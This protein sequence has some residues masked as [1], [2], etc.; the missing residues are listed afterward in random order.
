MRSWM[1]GWCTLVLMLSTVTTAG[2][3]V[4][5]E[6]SPEL[7]GATKRMLVAQGPERLLLDA[8][9]GAAVQ[10]P[11]LDEVRTSQ[12]G[13]LQWVLDRER[14]D[15]FGMRHVFYHQVFRPAP[16]SVN[17]PPELA[18]R[19]V[20]VH[21]SLV[22]LHYDPEGVLKSVGSKVFEDVVEV[23]GLAL[24]SASAAHDMAAW[25]LRHRAG[26]DA[27]DLGLHPSDVAA[28][29]LER[30]QLGLYSRGDGHRFDFVWSVE[31]LTADGELVHARV[32]GGT[33]ELL[34]WWRAGGPGSPGWSP[35]GAKT[36][37]PSCDPDPTSNVVVTGMA[38][39][40][41]VPGPVRPDLLASPSPTLAAWPGY[42]GAEVASIA[43]EVTHQGR[44]LSLINGMPEIR[45]YFGPG[46]T[47]A[48]QCAIDDLTKRLRLL[49]V[50][51]VGGGPRYDD[52]FMPAENL[53]VPGRAAADAY[54]HARTV[55]NL[56]RS[57]GWNGFSGTGLGLVVDAQHAQGGL[58]EFAPDHMHYTPSFRY[59]PGIPSV[60]FHARS[61]SVQAQRYSIA[62]ALDV[63]AHEIGHGVIFSLTEGLP[64]WEYRA[65]QPSYIGTQLHEAFA[66]VIGHIVEWSVH[67]A[68][69][70]YE[71]AD[72]MGGEDS[73]KVFGESD[74]RVDLDDG[75][76]PGGPLSLHASDPPSPAAEP[77]GTATR[78]PAALRLAVEG[79]R[80]PV[81]DRGQAQ[82]Q[83]WSGCE[84]GFTVHGLGH[85]R[86][87]D[88]FA[89][90]F[91]FLAAYAHHVDGWQDLADWAKIAAHD[92]WND[93]YRNAW[94][95]APCNDGL[96]MQRAVAE[97]FY[98][99][100]YPS[101][102]QWICTCTPT[103]PELE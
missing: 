27:E 54:H 65:Q 22:G 40:Q 102:S 58:A 15:R 51:T 78:L 16:G 3:G 86:R 57:Y 10:A 66:D 81:C 37:G 61:A 75:P 1:L 32:H 42:S 38:Q 70:G 83:G 74:R 60:L 2:A 59:A 103:C 98:A 73:F 90:F 7:T 97:A 87:D 49:P 25:G 101:D 8:F 4:V 6:G 11:A 20:Q 72:W 52:I 9:S 45:V 89:T 92:V 53:V 63:V 84:Q 85:D 35:G 31:A 18:G 5:L 56:L 80:N 64:I 21:G 79:G 100:G 43:A 17:L 69:S 36:S 29:L 55:I 95:P 41:T 71:K 50:A 94:P 96:D 24:E 30:S 34:S 28:R 68:G 48:E 77:Y 19:G 82:T 47:S 33:G 99:V 46:T 93:T 39:N 23:G 14:V 12:G 91:Q 44:A 76:A 88:V 67:D 26:I 62:A 13:R